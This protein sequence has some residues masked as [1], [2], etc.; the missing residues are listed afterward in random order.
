MLQLIVLLLSAVI[1]AGLLYH[2]LLLVLGYRAH[3]HMVTAFSTNHRFAVAIPAHNEEAVIDRTIARLRQMDY[4]AA[5][6][7]VHVV[8][9]HCS[10]ATA[11]VASAAGAFVHERSEGPRGRKGY[12]LAWLLKRLLKDP[13][14]YDAVAVFDADSQVATD[15]LSQVSIILAAGGKAVQGRHVIANPDA[16]LFSALADADMRLNN[17]LRNQAKENIGLSA[18][19]MGDAMCFYRDLLESV[20]FGAQS[21]VEDREYGIHLVTQGVRVHYAP[22]AVS[23]G[24]A[25]SRWS[26]ATG[27]RLRWYGGGFELQKRYL[28]PLLATVWSRRSM[29]ALDLV[30]ELSLPSF[31]TLAMLAVGLALMQFVLLVIGVQTPLML[32]IILAAAAFVFPLLGLLAERAPWH[33]YRA[34][35]LGPAYVAWRVWLGLAVRIR[36]GRVPWTRTRRAEEQGLH[37]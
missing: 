5:L 10:D 3:R 1:G 2:Y 26:D 32:G 17:R 14:H 11:Q 15:F 4:P 30:L 23:S 35:L 20:P 19:L 29:A 12:A 22:D 25:V 18:R 34:M 16:S 36:G 8:A 28:A 13:K 37:K 31:S 21:L 33:C 27:Q 6:C 7:D 9:D 24:Q